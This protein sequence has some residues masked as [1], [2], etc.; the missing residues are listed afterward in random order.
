MPMVDWRNTSPEIRDSGAEIAVINIGSTEQHG[1]HL[2]VGTDTMIG[3][4]IA[5]GVAEKLGA[6]LLP[7]FAVGNCQEHMGR[8]GTVWM[9]PQTLFAM[10]TDVCLSLREQGFRRIVIIPT[11]G[12]L[13]VLKPAVREL[14][15]NHPD[16]IVLL[17]QD[18]STASG[19]GERVLVGQGMDLH[20]GEAETSMMLHI[21][22]ETVKM[23]R[24]VDALPAVGREYLD[25]AAVGQISPSGVWGEARLGAADKGR[26]LLEARIEAIAG[27]CRKTFA[28]VE[29]LRGRPL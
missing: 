22:P 26:R 7:T 17:A 20:A 10:V 28:R 13:W 29:E 8:A 15:L 11:H 6:Y 18:Y 23:E 4:H 12:G 14:N 24:A 21:D 16:L 2:P 3:Q 5:R 27:Y 25:Y 1:A 19:D 9:K